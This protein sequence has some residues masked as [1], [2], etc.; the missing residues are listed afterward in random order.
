MRSRAFVYELSGNARANTREIHG[1][2]AKYGDARRYVQVC[3]NTSNERRT[4][5]KGRWSLQW[6][7]TAVDRADGRAN[8]PKPDQ[9]AKA[10]APRQDWR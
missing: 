7:R 5:G 2:V 1:R 10:I 9:S 3:M 4:H 6:S 8:S